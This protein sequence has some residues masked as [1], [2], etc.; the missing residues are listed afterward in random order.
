LEDAVFIKVRSTYHVTKTV[1]KKQF[2][3]EM[4]EKYGD[5]EMSMLNRGRQGNANRKMQ[6]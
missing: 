5:D 1:V 3:K 6:M 4:D 2:D